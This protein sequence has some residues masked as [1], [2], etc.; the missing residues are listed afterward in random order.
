MA[1]TRRAFLALAVLFV[2]IPQAA[3]QAAQA[4]QAAPR[5]E[6]LDRAF[7]QALR[8]WQVP[9]MAVAIVKDGQVVL[10]RGYGVRELGRPE[11]VDE[12]TLFA[13]ASNTKAFTSAAVAMLV[14]E[15]KLSW[16]DRVQTHLPYFELYDP[17]VS[18]EMRVRDLLSHRSGLGT[19]S[20]DLLW[21]GTSYSREE[22]VRRARY[23]KPVAPF[24]ASYRYNNLMFIAAGEVVA[25]VSGMSWDDFVRARIFEP[26]GMSATV[27]SVRALD[28]RANRATPH[29]PTYGPPKPFAWY[30][31][32]AMAPAGGV[33]S[34]AADMAKW[35][36]LHLERGV[37]D[38]KTLFS[39]E[40]SRLMWTPH[41]S[42]T[43]DRAAQQ[44][45]PSTHFRGY[46]LGWSLSDYQGR[47]V[48]EHGGAYDG[49]YSQVVLLPEERL[50][51]VV[52]TN[53][54]TGIGG[55]LKYVVLDEFLGSTGHDWS[56]ESLERARK[57]EAA[58]AE[59]VAKVERAR[60]ADTK[61]SLPL[62]AY[63]GRYPSDLYGD[64]E[65]KVENG[66][67]VLRL[68]PN[69]DLVADLTHWHF[70]TFHLRWRNA[71]TWFGDGKAQFVLDNQA[72]VTELKLDVP[73]EDIWF[74]EPQFLRSP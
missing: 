57:R 14:A 55:A 67:L 28:G 2:F 15:K 11:P 54:M 26:L 63:A 68:L 49:M 20:G 22:V 25:K 19:F 65:V 8:D 58:H 16:D 18:H 21:Y 44:R 50:G 6:V 12:H 34:S 56:R 3:P 52:L 9:G 23:L 48:V 59:D 4:V 29:G 62:E 70:D 43:I 41:V 30:N 1:W 64:A 47:L 45:V 5:A 69:P 72:R 27:T 38:G 53:S 51:L 73:N 24:R 61:P 42:F 17:W 13:I 33:I 32:D 36:R 46:G 74:W 60:V 66:A 35:L 31:W 7:A 71:F 37:S 40:T 10:A 39:E